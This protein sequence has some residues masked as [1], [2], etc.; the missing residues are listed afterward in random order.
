V[1]GYEGLRLGQKSNALVELETELRRNRI[2]IMNGKQK[3]RRRRTAIVK[4]NIVKSYAEASSRSLAPYPPSPFPPS[5]PPPS[6]PPF[7]FPPF[8]RCSRGEGGGRGGGGQGLSPL[9]GV[10]F[11]RKAR[12]SS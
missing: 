4:A 12:I 9:G 11:I 5:L 3:G 2:T 6:P 7:S 8:S 1:N 10:G